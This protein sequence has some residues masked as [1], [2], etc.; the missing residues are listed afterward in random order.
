MVEQAEHDALAVHRRDGRNAEVELARLEANTNPSVLWPPPLGD[1]QFRQE[2]D[3][4]DD[5]MMEMAR[6]LGR[7]SQHAIDAVARG[8]PGARCL[9]VDV[10]RGRVVRV[11][12]EEVHIPDYRRLVRQVAHVGGQRV[13]GGVAARV[14][15]CQ[16]HAPVGARGE[17]LDQRLQLRPRDGRDRNR[18]AIGESDVV[19]AVEDRPLRCGDDQ[20]SV[21]GQRLGTE[22]VVGQEL[23]GQLGRQR[24]HQGCVEARQVAQRA[25]VQSV[26]GSWKWNVLFRAVCQPGPRNAV[27]TMGLSMAMSFTHRHSKIGMRLALRWGRLTARASSAHFLRCSKT[28]MWITSRFGGVHDTNIRLIEAPGAPIYG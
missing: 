3:A 20:R 17:A 18:A 19:R 11:A 9:E 25:F 12:H 4:R 21:V 15:P 8:Q 7:G 5:G 10:A 27:V 23:A 14:D 22:A 1:V 24:L 13:A 2:L 16:L 28:A 26:A 6:G